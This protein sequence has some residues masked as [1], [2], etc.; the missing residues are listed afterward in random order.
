MKNF[1]FVLALIFVGHAA[2]QTAKNP[3]RV[4]GEG[5]TEEQA[6]QN[7][8]RT[9]IELSVG[10]VVV[11]DRQTVNGNLNKDE[12]LNYAAGYVTDFKVIDT[13]LLSS[14]TLVIMDVWVNKS[15]LADRILGA[16][17]KPEALDGD[18][19]LSKLQ[20][21][22]YAKQNGDRLLKQV[23]SDFPSKAFTISNDDTQIYVDGNRTPWLF[24][25]YAM[26][27]NYNYLMAIN[28]AM[29]ILATAKNSVISPT[30][31]RLTGQ[32][33][34]GYVTIMAKNPKD[35][36]FGNQWTHQ[37]PDNASM[38]LL[39]DILVDKE[40]YIMVNIKNVQ[41]VSVWRTCM[42]P[43]WAQGKAFYS[44]RENVSF[45]GNTVETGYLKLNIELSPN[46]D[47]KLK[48]ASSI[49]LSIVSKYECK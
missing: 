16:S 9:A 28:E 18:K 11:S 37:M 21:L 38:N 44:A 5:A 39:L 15:K 49:E 3:I 29:S 12:I 27:W 46:L 24:I 32:S 36:V 23:M 42:Q 20:T 8:F 10:S 19:Q 6:K 41:A 30:M 35:Y 4:H 7:A 43:Q 22:L 34:K 31:D 40:P 47:T 48:E 17:T 2:A 14:K 1:I 13:V 26:A 25:P 33:P 45:Y